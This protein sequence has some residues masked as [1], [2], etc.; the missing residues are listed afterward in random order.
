M[1]IFLLDKS[2]SAEQVAKVIEESRKRGI[3]LDLH[4]S[5]D[6][7]KLKDDPLFYCNLKSAGRD[8]V[9]AYVLENMILPGEV[10]SWSGVNSDGAGKSSSVSANFRS[11]S[12]GPR[13][14]VSNGFM[15]L[16][17]LRHYNSTNYEVFSI[18]KKSKDYLITID[19]PSE[20][21][22]SDSPIA[23]GLGKEGMRELAIVRREF[24]DFVLGL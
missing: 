14:I 18:D 16:Y 8:S 11:D 10:L 2:L 3:D 21:P 13:V 20:S 1:S 22:Q 12:L 24:A 7:R 9:R 5:D 19:N 17:G 6:G 4:R 15:E 23:I